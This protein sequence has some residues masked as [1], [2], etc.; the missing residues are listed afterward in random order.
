M[1]EK[2]IEVSLTDVNDEDT[3]IEVHNVATSEFGKLAAAKFMRDM[4]IIL[5][6]QNGGKELTLFDSDE[7]V[8]EDE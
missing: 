8:E 7:E 3:T 2:I 6:G 4:A 1:N 5:Y